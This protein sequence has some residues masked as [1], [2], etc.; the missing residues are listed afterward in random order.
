ME[1]RIYFTTTC[2]PT[3]MTLPQLTGFSSNTDKNIKLSDFIEELSTC[4][5]VFSSIK[6]GALNNTLSKK[7]ISWE[8]IDKIQANI[9]DV[10]FEIQVN[11]LENYLVKYSDKPELPK[12]C[13]LVIN[14]FSIY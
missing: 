8:Q 14:R 11:G 4:N 3:K 12:Y 9:G 10:I 5:N 7:G 2:V 13:N 6:N 1:K